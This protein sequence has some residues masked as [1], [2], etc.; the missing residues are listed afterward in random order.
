MQVLGGLL[1]RSGLGQMIG[2]LVRVLV[3]D[4]ACSLLDGL[5]DPPVQALAAQRRE[6]AEQVW[7]ICSW[8]KTKRG[9]RPFLGG[10]QARALGLFQ[11]V[12]Q[13]LLAGVRHRRQEARR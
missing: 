3:E 5:G 9:L 1:A 12:E 6:A 2:E 13:R 4:V 10:D 7:R 11:G 8:A